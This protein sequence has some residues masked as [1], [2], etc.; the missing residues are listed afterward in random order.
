MLLFEKGNELDLK[1]LVQVAFNFYLFLHTY[2]QQY[3]EIIF[4]I[5]IKI[6]LNY[7]RGIGRNT[8]T[9]FINIFGLNDFRFRVGLLYC[10]RKLITLRRLVGKT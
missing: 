7:P 10:R 1:G 6:R 3:H 9:F 4:P 2:S 5:S 8:A